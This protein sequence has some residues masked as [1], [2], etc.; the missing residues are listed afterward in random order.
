MASEGKKVLLIDGDLRRPAINKYFKQPN[1]LGLTNY[2]VGD[3]ELKDI[4]LKT[5]VDGL[6]VILTGPIPP[7]PGKLVESNK[8]HNLIK[9]METMYDLVVVDTPP[10]LAASDALVLGGWT[11]GIILLTQSGRAVTSNVADI[12]DSFKR[13]SV[14]LTGVVL[15][16]VHRRL[17][18]YY[19]YYHTK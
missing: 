2:M 10:V 19:Y 16:R 4:Q 11:D 1:D 12:I 13:A 5:D 14:N 18:A 3:A 9:E 17:S 15:N 8:M 7:D 6:Y